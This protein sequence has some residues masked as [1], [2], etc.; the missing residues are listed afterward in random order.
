MIFS[1]IYL[2]YILRIVSF[3][4]VASFLVIIFY[5]L[6]CVLWRVLCMHMHV[7]ING[8]IVAVVRYSMLVLYRF[9]CFVPFCGRFVPFCTVSVRLGTPIIYRFVPFVPF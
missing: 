7:T 1:S 3:F 6:C 9:E 8:R 5:L 2:S 4:S